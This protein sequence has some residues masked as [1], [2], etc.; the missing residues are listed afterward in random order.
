MNT[1]VTAPH[2]QYTETFTKSAYREKRKARH[3]SFC[4]IQY[5]QA[6]F[7]LELG[8]KTGSSQRL[9]A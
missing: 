4:E 5:I 6:E 7:T 9:L 2:G 3:H 8:S 1:V